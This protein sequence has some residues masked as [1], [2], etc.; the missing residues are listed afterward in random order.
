MNL[1]INIVGRIAAGRIE[2]CGS[3]GSVYYVDEK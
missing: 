3:G 2:K 1:I